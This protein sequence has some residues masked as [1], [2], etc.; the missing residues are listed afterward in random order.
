MMDKDGRRVKEME[1]AE[2]IFLTLVAEYQMMSLKH[3]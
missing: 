3:V 2:R 1:E